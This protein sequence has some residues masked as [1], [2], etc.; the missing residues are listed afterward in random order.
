[1]QTLQQLSGYSTVS[2][3]AKHLCLQKERINAELNDTIKQQVPA[4]TESANPELPPALFEQLCAH[5]NELLRLLQD[6][7]VGNFQF[8]AEFAR[9]RAEHFFPLESLL[10]AYRSSQKV[11]ARWLRKAIVNTRVSKEISSDVITAVSDFI[12]EYTDTVSTI[13][14]ANYVNHSRLMA[15]IAGDQRTELLTLLLEGFD[16]S[17]GRVA[18]ILRNAGY[19]DTRQSFCVIVA[20][21]VDPAEMHRPERARR[22]ADYLDNVLHHLPGKRLVDMHRNRVTI[23]FSHARRASGWSAPVASLAKKIKNELLTVGNAVLIG[24]SNDVA[25]TS[26]IPAAY[27]EA[28][29]AF[30][31]SHVGDRVVQF[32]DIPMQ[33]LLLHFARDDFQRILPSWAK[34]LIEADLACGGTLIATLKA[35]ADANMNILK[36]AQQLSV[37]PNTV[38]A[39]F[40]KINELSGQDARSYSAL[41]ELL[42]V[43]DFGSNGELRSGL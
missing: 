15:D 31:M 21:S 3:M 42:I 43:A 6:G 29:L 16:E 38:Y 18:S 34:K 36:A 39:R 33:K 7:P 17:D 27:R 30:E 2:T 35:Y 22:L 28:E 20:Q 4:F 19:L 26:Q 11:Y 8:V 13:A 10:H 5:T 37:H 25:S 9:K 1:M 23:I 32:T 41:N 12:F 40:E 24:V 14:A